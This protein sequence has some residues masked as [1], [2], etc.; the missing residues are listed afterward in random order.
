MGVIC[1]IHNIILYAPHHLHIF[2]FLVNIINIMFNKKL[3]YF[4]IKY[5]YHITFIIFNS[6]N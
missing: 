4:S 2:V 3:K 6:L 1:T 5:K